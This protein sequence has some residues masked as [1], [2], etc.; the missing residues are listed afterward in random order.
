MSEEF[1]NMTVSLTFSELQAIDQEDIILLVDVDSAVN[2]SNACIANKSADRIEVLTLWI[3]KLLKAYLEESVCCLRA[4]K[5]MCQWFYLESD[6]SK[7]VNSD[8][9]KLFKETLAFLIVSRNHLLKAGERLV[10]FFAYLLL[11][12]ID[13]I[14]GEGKET[15]QQLLADLQLAVLSLLKENTSEAKTFHPRITPLM[16]RIIEIADFER[17]TLE[18]LELPVKTSETITFMCV[19]YMSCVNLKD[20]PLPQWLK[21]TVLHLCKMV[22]G[23]LEGL[24]ENDVLTVPA[25][26]LK[27]FMEVVRAYFLML[28]QIF[29]NSATH[30]DQDVAVCLM[31]LFMCEEATSSYYSDKDIQHLISSYVRPNIMELYELVYS[32][33]ECQEYLLSSILG[34]PE[35]DYFEVCIDF[36][37]AVST[38]EA[39]VLPN[40]CQT[41]K[42]IFEYLFKDSTNFVNA[43]R[44]EQVMD[45]FGSLLYLVANRELHSYF[46][47][48]IFQKD[49]ITSQVCADILMLCY[50]L[51]EENK[52]W[53]LSAIEQAVAFWNKCNNSYSMFSHNPSQWHV[54]RFLKYFHC[55]GKLELPALSIRNYRHLLAVITEDEHIGIKLL[56]RLDCVS[57]SVPTKVEVY[58]EMTALLE[59]LVKHRNTDCSQWFQRTSEMAKQLMSLEKSTTFTSTY[60]KLLGSA[61]K[62]TQLLILRGLSPDNGCTNW[63]RQRFIDACKVSDDAQLKAFSARHSIEAE[64]QLLL[65]ALRQKPKTADTLVDGLLDVSKLSYTRNS[66]HKCLV[67]SLKR[68]RSEIP[69][70]QILLDIYESSLQLS[71]SREDFDATDWD[72]LK[73]VLANLSSILPR[74]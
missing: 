7:G 4:V 30:V 13:F 10:H 69:T 19:H 51:K 29:S 44:Y 23:Y 57:S 74:P 52:C 62:S 43:E 6:H 16:Q 48:G 3:S 22:L 68:K 20:E 38:D 18:D 53:S 34:P 45:S 61:N 15:E 60:F 63:H 26:N 31:D 59:L 72:L 67:S 35:E 73:K 55:L 65:Q 70:K 33:D 8:Q 66:E 58:Y 17:R 56:K 64:V 40:T 2:I 49:I 21:E 12:M 54:Q 42:K 50:R 37:T 36:V 71:Q 41:L 46:C 47:A 9:K 1:E 11:T 28:Q 25:E 27:G 5:E 14:L 32:F 24:Y 39:V